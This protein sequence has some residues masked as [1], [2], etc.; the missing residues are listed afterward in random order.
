VEVYLAFCRTLGFG[1]NHENF[2]KRNAG[3]DYA[4]ARLGAAEGR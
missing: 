3:I 1:N 2:D 4:R